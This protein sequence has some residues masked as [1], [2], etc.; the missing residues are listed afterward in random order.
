[1]AEIEFAAKI[2]SDNG[3]IL[4]AKVF[5]ATVPAKAM[6]AASA[7]A[8]LDEAFGKCATELVI[9]AAGIM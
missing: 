2:M 7:A 4:G 1:M 6:N 9:W 5:R 8:A 3:R